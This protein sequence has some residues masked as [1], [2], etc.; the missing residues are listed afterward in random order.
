MVGSLGN[1]WR[2]MSCKFGHSVGMVVTI[3]ATIALGRSDLLNA[4]SITVVLGERNKDMKG[5]NCPV[6]NR[7]RKSPRFE[8]SGP[9]IA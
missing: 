3:E 7:N 6:A 2:V 9:S 8:K 1:S 5:M 4:M